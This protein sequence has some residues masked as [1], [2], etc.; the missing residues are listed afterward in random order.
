MSCISRLDNRQRGRNLI[1]LLSLLLALVIPAP[2]LLAGDDDHDRNNDREHG[3]FVDPIVGSWILHITVKTFTFT[4]PTVTPPTLPLLFDNMT[5]FWEDGNT[6]SS[7]PTQGTAYGVWKKVGPRMYITKIVQVNS[8]TT[9]GT[10]FGGSPTPITLTPQGDQMSGLF[11]GI[12][13]DSTG[14]T[15]LARFAG[16]VTVDR[17]TF[18]STP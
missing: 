14:K 12:T 15:V 11:Q 3:R 13:T 9:L 16:E 1:R 2:L 18:N 10:V 8:D 7:D 17:I 4:D 5:A 6:T